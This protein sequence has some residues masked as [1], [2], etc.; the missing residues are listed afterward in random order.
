VGHKI[1]F[2]PTLSAAVMIHMC[3]PDDRQ[4]ARDILRYLSAHKAAQDT[5]DGIVEWWLL[6]QKIKRETRHVQ[7]VLDELVARKLISSRTTRDSRTHYRIN[8][9]KVKEISTVLETADL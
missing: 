7:K 6:E 9:R 3:A 8:R 1:A 5:F 4:I 2:D